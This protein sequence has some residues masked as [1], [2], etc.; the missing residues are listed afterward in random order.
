MRPTKEK[1]ATPKSSWRDLMSLLCNAVHS[2]ITAIFP[3]AVDIYKDI[4]TV[5]SH[6]HFF[7]KPYLHIKFKYSLYYCLNLKFISWINEINKFYSLKKL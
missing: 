5:S 4:D 3:N 7:S 1:T 6:H 2:L